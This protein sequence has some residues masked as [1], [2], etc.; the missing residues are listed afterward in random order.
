[1][2][3][4]KT[5][6]QQKVLLSKKILMKVKPVLCFES[7]FTLKMKPGFWDNKF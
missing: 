6:I 4:P 5:Y 3:F 7:S 1:M 2:F